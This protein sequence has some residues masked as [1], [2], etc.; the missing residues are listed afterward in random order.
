MSKHKRLLELLSERSQKPVLNKLV[1]DFRTLDSTLVETPH[2]LH[3][4]NNPQWSLY[5][6]LSA[7][8]RPTEVFRPLPRHKIV[9]VKFP[10]PPPIIPDLYRKRSSQAKLSQ[11]VT[12]RILCINKDEEEVDF[13]WQRYLQYCRTQRQA[14]EAVY[15]Q[16]MSDILNV[17]LCSFLRN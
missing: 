14:S 16:F 5:K 12:D 11:E 4:R 6:Q 15:N 7:Y 9:Q 8:M 2:G 17:R 3:I 1:D 13:Q 10:I